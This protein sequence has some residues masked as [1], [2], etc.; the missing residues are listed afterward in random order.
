MHVES[1]MFTRE[2]LDVKEARVIELFS[3]L[4]SYCIALEEVRVT[5]EVHLVDLFISKIEVLRKEL[6]DSLPL[7]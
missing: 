3:F 5:K 7:N 6:A 2:P 4:N 1:E